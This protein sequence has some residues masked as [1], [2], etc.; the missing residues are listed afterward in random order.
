MDGV[1]RKL[2]PLTDGPSL[3]HMDFRPGNI[4]V[5]KNQVVGIIDFESLR[6]GATEMDFTKVNRDIFMKYPETMEHI[7]K[8]ATFRFTEC[9]HFISERANLL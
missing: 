1:F 8:M 4:L 5:Y 6:I 3:I 9:C 2:L 7:R